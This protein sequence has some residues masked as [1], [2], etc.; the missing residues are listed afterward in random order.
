VS[1]G[2]EFACASPSRTSPAISG[3]HGWSSLD[4][5]IDGTVVLPTNDQYDSAKAVFNARFAT[6]TPVA[7]VTVKSTDDVRKAVAFA[8]GNGIKVA[9]RSGGHSYTGASTANGAM[10]VDLRQFPRGLTV[11]D[12]RALATISPAAELDSVQTELAARGRSIPSGSCPSVGVGLTLGGGLVADARSGRCAVARWQFR[13][14]HIADVPHVS[15][16]RQGR[17]H[18]RLPLG[19][20]CTGRPGLAR[21]AA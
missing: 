2:G 11:D 12:E 21:L 5:A 6:S 1:V 16:H 4:D 3:P 8:A 18:P 13:N 15:H 10:V 20:R 17:R 9:P 19:G 14:R 7:V